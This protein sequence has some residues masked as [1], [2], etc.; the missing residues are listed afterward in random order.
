MS[1]EYFKDGVDLSPSNSYVSIAQVNMNCTEQT[2][3][4]REKLIDANAQLES[5]Y[6]YI[7]TLPLAVFSIGMFMFL[8]G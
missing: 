1:V 2:E 7:F 3:K 5:Q 4:E 6:V 8:M